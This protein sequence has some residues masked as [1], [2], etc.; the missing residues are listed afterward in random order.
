[1]KLKVGD[2]APPFT[3]TTTDGSQVSLA[4]YAGKKL[5]LYF[6]P[7]DAT[8]GC[9]RQACSLRDH[10]AEIRAKGAEVLGVSTQ[11]R[12]SHQRF[13]GKYRLNFPLLADTDK[14]VA[15]AY[16]AI[17]GGGLMGLAFNFLGVANRITFIIDERGKI[18]H[19]IDNPDC[20]NHAEEVLTLL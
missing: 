14:T 2:P 8:P 18:A 17:G 7:K 5:V 19:I 10:K 11:D 9:T 12:A 6:Y 15:K 20:A 4:D 13:T 3:G 1:M 16:G